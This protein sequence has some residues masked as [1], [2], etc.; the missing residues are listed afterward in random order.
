MLSRPRCQTALAQ[1]KARYEC[2]LIQ[3]SDVDQNMDHYL[4]FCGVTAQ[5][6]HRH[7]WLL[8]YVSKIKIGPQVQL[9]GVQNRSIWR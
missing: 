8:L 4:K 2:G 3:V 5:P 9:D 6:L 1:T 7:G